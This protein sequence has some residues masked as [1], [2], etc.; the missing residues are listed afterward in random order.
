MPRRSKGRGGL[1]PQLKQVGRGGTFSLL[2]PLAAFGHPVPWEV[3]THTGEGHLPYS[4]HSSGADPIKYTRKM[5]TGVWVAG[6]E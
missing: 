1:P 2:P 3:P 6:E 4:A 5:V